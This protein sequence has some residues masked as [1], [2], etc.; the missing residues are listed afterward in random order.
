MGDV[1]VIGRADVRAYKFGEEHFQLNLYNKMRVFLAMHILSQ[2]MIRMIKDYCDL[3]EN[4]IKDWDPFIE[5]IDKIDRLVDICNTRKDR[6]VECLNCPQH[7]HVFELFSILQLFEE[8]RKE[9]GGFNEKFI[10]RQTYEDL[11]WLVFG[12][13]GIACYYLKDNKSRWMNQKNGGSDPCEH[14]FAK[15]RQVNPLPTL[16]QCREI[17][18]KLSGVKIGTSNM[19]TFNS[20]NNTGGVK[21]EHEMYIEKVPHRK[22]LN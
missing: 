21:R 16:K 22:K 11:Q 8:W 5:V 4:D 1:D 9:A 20:K 12:M 14:F 19:F 17:T 7:P 10:T 3:N 2:T 6:G 18:S 15:T 13:V